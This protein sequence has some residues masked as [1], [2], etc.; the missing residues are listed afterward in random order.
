[1]LY[2]FH[3]KSTL[4]SLNKNML[5]AKN[6]NFKRRDIKQQINVPPSLKFFSRRRTE[7]II[8]GGQYSLKFFLTGQIN[9]Y[10]INFSFFYNNKKLNIFWY[11]VHHNNKFALK[12]SITEIAEHL[13]LV[14]TWIFI[15]HTMGTV[16][17]REK[18]T[19]KY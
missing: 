10:N 6:F 18:G 11:Y 5:E 14:L 12:K 1:M 9:K 17:V 8:F 16:C 3:F 19:S 13:I 15:Y 7:F 4:N 2:N